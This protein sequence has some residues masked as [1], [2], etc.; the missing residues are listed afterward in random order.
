MISVLANKHYLKYNSRAT[1]FAFA[2]KNP[3]AIYATDINDENLADLA[4]DIKESTGVDCISKRV[5]ASSDEDIKGV[6]ANALETYGRLDVFF[7]NAGIAVG[8]LPM[9]TDTKD[10]FLRI[11]SVN[12]WRYIIIH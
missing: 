1:V 3:K 9:A 4:K 5:D 11:M 12:T 7:A 2:K 10:A 6:I 8:S